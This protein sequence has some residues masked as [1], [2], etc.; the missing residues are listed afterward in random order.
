MFITNITKSDE[1]RFR[2]AIISKILTYLNYIRV[3]LERHTG[4]NQ[5]M[6]GVLQM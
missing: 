5:G 2:E 6:G 3:I 4:Q 1:D